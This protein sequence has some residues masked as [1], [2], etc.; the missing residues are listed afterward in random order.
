MPSSWEPRRKEL[1]RSNQP[2]R[3]SRGDDGVEEQLVLPGSAVHH[4]FAVGAGGHV[5][6]DGC[7]GLRI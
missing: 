2:V 1:V 6:K 5:P 7:G 3:A 4:S